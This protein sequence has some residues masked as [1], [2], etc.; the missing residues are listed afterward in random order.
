[1]PEVPGGFGHDDF[2]IRQC[3]AAGGVPIDHAFAPVDVPLLVE[4]HEGLEDG[5]R[6]L[7]VHGKAFAGPIARAAEFFELLDDD[8]AVFVFPFPDFFQELFPAEIVAVF[9]DALFAQGLLDDGLRCD[10]GMIGA[11]QPEDFIALHPFPPGEDV[12][13]GV[14]E[15]VA[16]GEDAGDV[17]RGDDD[18]IRRLGGSRI[19][20]EVALRQPIGVPLIFH[21]LRVVGFGNFGAHTGLFLPD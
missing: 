12:L 15:H 18:G 1:M 16:H 14:V 21:G 4:V 19:G 2:F 13:Q 7:L 8:A 6:I 20:G 5:V 11:W 9:D 10:A 17:G 3:G